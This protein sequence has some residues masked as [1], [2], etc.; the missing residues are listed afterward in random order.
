LLALTFETLPLA[1]SSS[2]EGLSRISVAM[3]VASLVV[4][5]IELAG[6]AL[7]VTGFWNLANRKS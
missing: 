1:A 5:F 7:I 3:G 6:I 4:A 2:R